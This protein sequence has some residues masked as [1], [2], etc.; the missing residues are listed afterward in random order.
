MTEITLWLYGKPEWELGDMSEMTGEQFKEH[1]KELMERLNKIGDIVTKLEN[2]E[3][4]KSGGLYDL[5]LY[6]DIS[7]DDAKK[8]LT[9]LGLDLKILN[10]RD[11]SEDY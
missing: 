10:L 1:G 4:S 8:E 6:K 3:W 11:D 2:N 5:F 7:L 9:E